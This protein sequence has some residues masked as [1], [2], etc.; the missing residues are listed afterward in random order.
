MLESI[1]EG[2]QC[3]LRLRLGGGGQVENDH[4]QQSHVSGQPFL[5]DALHQGLAHEVLVVLGEDDLQL[6]AH[7]EQ[8]IV[9]AGHGAVNHHTDGLVTELNETTLAG[10]DAGVL[11]DEWRNKYKMFST[12]RPSCALTTQPA[13]G[14]ISVLPLTR[15]TTNEG[16][17]F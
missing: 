12:L 10:L 15:H 13:V 2:W 5:H 9:V 16:K 3:D 17:R 4:L 8:L 11:R 6:I 7:G 14:R 1:R